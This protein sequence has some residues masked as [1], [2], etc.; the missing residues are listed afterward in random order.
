MRITNNMVSRNSLISLQRSLKAMN[1]A[2]ERATDGLRVEKASDDPSAATSIMASGSSIRAIDQYKRN[3]NSARARLDREETVLDSVTQVL[4][5][6]KELGL[7]QGSSTAD[8]QTRNTAKAEIDQLLQTVVQL[9]NSQHQGEYLFGGDQS[10]VAP[11]NSNTPPF[12]AAAPTGTRRTEISSA[13]SVRTNHNGTEIFLNTGVLAA[14]DQLSTALGANDQTGIQNSLSQLDSA[15][16]GV[17]VLVGETGAA[18]QQLD[19]A[20]SNLDALDTSLRSFKS[21]LQDVD[22]EKAVSELVGRQTAYQAAMLATSRVLSLN[23]ADYL[24]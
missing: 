4:E 11:F 24:R 14:L 1:E 15:H 7:Q 19:V 12:T 2:Q 20:T 22:I 3:I 10:N 5:R 6:A 17:Q 23:L 18:S 8:A 21:Q 13:L 9:G 16:A